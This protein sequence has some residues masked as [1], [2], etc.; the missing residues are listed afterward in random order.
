MRPDLRRIVAVE[1]HR[2]RSGRCPVRVHSLGTGETFVIEPSPDGFIDVASGMTV[3]SRGSEIVLPD[4]SGPI[5]LTL[6]GDVL[7]EGK[8]Y[9][10]GEP[11]FGRA[12]GGSSVTLY[13]RAQ[14]DFFQ[15]AL[16][17]EDDRI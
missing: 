11:F 4:G 16:G 9:P 6:I 5:E 3:R 15:Y 17:T 10:G 2:R 7:F 13:D 12:G 14:N 8:E 1:A